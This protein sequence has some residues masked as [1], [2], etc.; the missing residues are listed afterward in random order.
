MNNEMNDFSIPNTNNAFGYIPSLTNFVRLGKCPLFFIT[1]V[2]VEFLSN[3]TLYFV[4][5]AALGSRIITST[6]QTL[7]QV[8]D[9]NITSEEAVATW[10]FHD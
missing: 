10:R 7:W 3:E 1:L 5:G 8:L 4:V 2:I 9:R 6:S